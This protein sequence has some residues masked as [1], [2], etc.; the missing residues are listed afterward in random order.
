M[1]LVSSISSIFC[2]TVRNFRGIIE[3]YLRY[4]YEW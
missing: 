1:Y 4:I 3:V 2:L